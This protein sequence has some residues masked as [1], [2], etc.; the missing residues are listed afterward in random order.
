[1]IKE[2]KITIKY[3]FD[4]KPYVSRITGIEHYSLYARVTY[5][6]E[7][8]KFTIQRLN[9]EWE[10]TETS[11]HVKRDNINSLTE[12][13][14]KI[15]SSILKPYKHLEEIIRYEV[16][17]SPKNYSLKGLKSRLDRY[18]KSIRW[19]TDVPRALESTFKGLMD[20]TMV[21]ALN[22]IIMG[23]A[24]FGCAEALNFIGFHVEDYSSKIPSR[25]K[26]LVIGHLLFRMVFDKEPYET[27]I[28]GINGDSCY[29]WFINSNLKNDFKRKLLKENALHN[30]NF[31]IGYSV[32]LND[33]GFSLDKIDDYI[34]ALDNYIHFSSS[35]AYD[36]PSAHISY[37]QD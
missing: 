22:S 1:M 5:N 36:N 23:E 6:R 11:I 27:E 21:F 7:T 32:V 12:L 28:Y 20:K 26:K 33:L 37:F 10:L 30:N 2:K 31:P 14:E 3:Y 18:S 8:T 15:Y 9:D 13:G 35:L 4:D 29:E 25:L 19:A 17:F 24:E 34:N 16:G